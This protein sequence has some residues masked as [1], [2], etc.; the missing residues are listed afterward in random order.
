M[1]DDTLAFR[2]AATYKDRGGWI[3][4]PDAGIEDANDSELS[5]IRLKGLWQISEDFTADLTAIRHR[6]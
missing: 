3:D 1:I 2:V 6:S 5:S 4:R